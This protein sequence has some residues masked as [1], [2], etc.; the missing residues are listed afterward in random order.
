M[1]KFKS[2]GFKT[3]LINGANVFTCNISVSRI[4]NPPIIDGISIYQTDKPFG[5]NR[6]IKQTTQFTYTTTDYSDH[7]RMQ[8]ELGLFL[9]QLAIDKIKTKFNWAHPYIAQELVSDH[10]P[11]AEYLDF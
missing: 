1:L 6:L 8:T 11:I 9:E 3:I 7:S 4:T 10:N 2:F 5:K